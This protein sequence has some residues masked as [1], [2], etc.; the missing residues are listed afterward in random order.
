MDTVRVL[1]LVLMTGTKRLA[2]SPTHSD[3][4]T[5]NVLSLV[6]MTGTNDSDS[7]I[8]LTWPLS[9]YYHWS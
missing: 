1:S 4:A 2:V 3:M 6:F 9:K 5:V 7:T 8:T